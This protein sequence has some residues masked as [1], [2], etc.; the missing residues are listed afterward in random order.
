MLVKSITAAAQPR[1]SYSHHGYS[2]GLLAL[3]ALAV[4]KLGLGNLRKLALED[5]AC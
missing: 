3:G 5:W 4:G 1:A 2:D